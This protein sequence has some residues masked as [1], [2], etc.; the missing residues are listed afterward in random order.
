MALV[1]PIVEGADDGD[2]SGVGRP[3]GEV[4]AAFGEDVSAEFFVEA[5][6]GSFVEEI[7]VLLAEAGRDLGFLGGGSG[8][9]LRSLR[10][11]TTAC[12]G[13]CTQSG[14]ELSS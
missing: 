9:G 13:I 7:D 3:D 6:V 8:H 11:A 10:M 14:R 5:A 12:R 1:V 4:D 2:G